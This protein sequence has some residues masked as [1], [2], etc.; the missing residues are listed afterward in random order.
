MA[1]KNSFTHYDNEEEEEEGGSQPA[2]LPSLTM[3]TESKELRLLLLR[4]DSTVQTLR[5]L[6]YVS[7][8]PPPFAPELTSGGDVVTLRC[9]ICTSSGGRVPLFI[10]GAFQEDP[11]LEL[12]EDALK[13]VVVEGSEPLRLRLPEQHPCSSPTA[14]GLGAAPVRVWRSK[15]IASGSSGL[16]LHMTAPGWAAQVLRQLAGD[17]AF[18]GLA[19]LGVAGVEGNPVVARCARADLLKGDP[20]TAGLS[21]SGHLAPGP[22]AAG[23]NAKKVV[24]D[25]K[26][27]AALGSEKPEEAKG[28]PA[29]LPSWWEYAA[30]SKKRLWASPGDS[31]ER[32]KRFHLPGF[33]P[34]GTAAEGERQ[35]APQEDSRDALPVGTG[36]EDKQMEP[37]QQEH[38]QQQPDEHALGQRGLA[39]ASS[40]GPAADAG[41]E[42]RRDGGGGPQLPSG[43]TEG[44]AAPTDVAAARAVAATAAVAAPDAS[45]P[46]SPPLPDE[47]ASAVTPSA[48]AAAGGQVGP[49]GRPVPPEGAAAGGAEALGNTA[50]SA[51]TPNSNQ[52]A[53]TAAAAAAAEGT[54]QAAGAGDVPARSALS[55]HTSGGSGGGATPLLDAPSACCLPNEKELQPP[56]PIPPH[57][58]VALRPIPW[59]RRPRRKS[60]SSNSSKLS[61]AATTPAGAGALLPALASGQLPP[62]GDTHAATL[63]AGSDSPPAKGPGASTRANDGEGPHAASRPARAKAKPHGCNRKPLSEVAEDAFLADVAAFLVARSCGKLVPAGGMHNFPE[64]VLNGVQ[65]DLFTL[66]REVVSRGGFN[67]GNGIN[68]KGQIFS[69]MRNHSSTHRCT[70]VGNTL[71]KHYETYLLDYELAH[72]D[73]AKE[74]CMMCQKGT[75]GD[76]V[77]CGR[78]GEWAH[79]DCDPRNGLGF[80]KVRAGAP[81]MVL[82][83]A[84]VWF[85]RKTTR[86]L[87]GASTYAHPAAPAATALPKNLEAGAMCLRAKSRNQRRALGLENESC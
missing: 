30:P 51:A 31:R 33:F 55:E 4:D 49:G 5:L 40:E 42:G 79:F 61:P 73:V 72:N 64:A 48:G 65:L 81:A 54:P 25:G 58:L 85:V 23:P 76:W 52:D 45:E 69:K 46:T 18:T 2:S 47:E 86:N 24:S 63:P 39:S 53:A 41:A 19:A 70:G 50:H 71:K 26:G 15:A 34:G 16:D 20:G 83:G 67:V 6:H 11:Q 27:T 77:N 17:A 80:F 29:E 74:F 22:D 10:S 36:D 28:G 38:K 62:A 12:L 56:P 82:S 13:L 59:P 3:H 44:G 75:G 78:C 8:P 9:D 7:V 66:Y 87:T 84:L 60:R 35:V 68:W 1:L 37:L 32:A 21:N 14:T 57:L 43:Q